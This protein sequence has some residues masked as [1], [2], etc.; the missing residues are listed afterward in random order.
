M[1]SIHRYLVLFL[2]ASITLITFA[3]AIKG[4]NSSMSKATTLFD[5][6]LKSLAKTLISIDS[7]LPVAE[8]DD[9]ANLAFQIWQN[10]ALI[11]RSKNAP[12][13]RLTLFERGFREE[14]FLGQRWR[15]YAI[16]HRP[17]QRW[18]L[19]AQPVSHRFELAENLVIAAVTPLIFSIPL[20]ALVISMVVKRGLGSLLTLSGALRDKKA[21]DL[22]PIHL[23]NTPDELKPVTE[24]MNNLFARLDAAFSREK[25][26]ASD[27]AHELRT[28]LSV[29]KINTHNLVLELNS[30]GIEQS[31]LSYLEQGVERM[32]HVVDQILLLNRTSPDQFSANFSLINLNK[33][34]QKI[35]SSL[36][37]EIAERQQTIELDGDAVVVQGEEFALG[38]LLQNLISNASKYS[39]R[40]GQIRVLIQQVG[41]QPCICIEDS[42]PGIAENEYQRVFE[43]FYRVGGDR[44][45]SKIVG[46]GLG[47]AIVQHIAQLHHATLHLGRSALL[48]GLEFK[49]CFPSLKVDKND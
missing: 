47:L 4:Y 28:P 29:L 34:A 7:L 19:V 11:M 33:L 13:D 12:E 2:L 3:A 46:C 41:Q 8:L 15:T 16:E 30:K 20:L 24:T 31:N 18:V 23:P 10:D 44:H 49:V 38:I 14:N 9:E 43:R 22:A 32:S 27:A 39:P 26:F 37:P 45:D 25:R 48:G 35:I 1:N 36:Y 42:G 21:N 6:E 5:A 17:N 40:Q